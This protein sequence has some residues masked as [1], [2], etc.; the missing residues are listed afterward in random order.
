MNTLKL[1]AQIVM[2]RSKALKEHRVDTSSYS[3][4][5]QPQKSNDAQVWL[6]SAGLAK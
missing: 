3:G 4:V 2:K 1:A 6:K 5:Y